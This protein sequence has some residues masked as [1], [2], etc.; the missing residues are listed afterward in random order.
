MPDVFPLAPS[1]ANE[2]RLTEV[3]SIDHVSE[4]TRLL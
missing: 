3:L 2:R 4:P 1:D